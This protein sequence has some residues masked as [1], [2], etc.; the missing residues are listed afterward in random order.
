MRATSCTKLAR[1]LRAAHCLQR[2]RPNWPEHEINSSGLVSRQPRPRAKVH[3][4]RPAMGKRLVQLSGL[5]CAEAQILTSMLPGLHSPPHTWRNTHIDHSTLLNV[6]WHHWQP[7]PVRNPSAHRGVFSS[8]ANAII[9]CLN[10]TSSRSVSSP[11]LCFFRSVHASNVACFGHRC[12][13]NNPDRH[14]DRFE[15]K[16]PC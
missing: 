6:L 9:T 15:T 13:P 14:S 4:P 10:C 1:P 5:R 8:T 11:L 7:S 2:R 3:K 16:T 12:F